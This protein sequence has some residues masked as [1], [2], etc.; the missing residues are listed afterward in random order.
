MLASP[1]GEIWMNAAFMRFIECPPGEIDDPAR[2]ITAERRPFAVLENGRPIDPERLPSAI[3][4]R[5]QTIVAMPLQMR[6]HSGRTIDVLAFA[7]PTH[8]ETGEFL[9]GF[10]TCFDVSEQERQSNERVRFLADAGEALANAGTVDAVVETVQRLVLPRLGT[11]AAVMLLGESGDPASVSF[12]HLNSPDLQTALALRERH[13]LEARDFQLLARAAATGE[14]YYISDLTKTLQSQS[15]AKRYRSFMHDLIGA[16]RIAAAICVPM[17]MRGVSLGAIM[18]ADRRHGRFREEDL[19]LLEDLAR[20]GAGAL[21]NARLLQRHL[22]SSLSLQRALLPARLPHLE[23]VNFDAVYEPGEDEALVGG[24]WYDAFELQDGRVMVTIGDVTGR[25]LHAAVLMSKVR[26]SL[27][28]LSYYESDPAKLLDIA[29][30]TLQ[31]RH[32][33]AIV[34]ALVGV[35]DRRDLTFRYATAGHPMPFLRRG[36]AVILLPGHGLPIGLRDPGESSTV[37]VELAHGDVLLM[38][39]DGLIESTHDLAEGEARVRE[40]LRA[41]SSGEIA[42]HVE[43]VVL[44]RGSPDD[45]ALL[46]L[47]FMD[48]RGN[49]AKRT[50]GFDFDAQ[51]VRMARESRLCITAFLRELGA[52]EEKL[53]AA[54]LVYGELIS[55]VVRHAPGHVYA[56]IDWTGD[57][58]ELRV[59]DRGRGYD[60]RSSLPGDL[61]SESGRGLFIVEAFT[62]SFE[63]SRAPHGGSDVRALLDIPRLM[64]AQR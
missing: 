27:S 9:G 8:H 5:G 64:V 14:S 54:E 36:E 52:P 62:R 35:V 49:A 42:H 21:E 44:P 53:H 45:V 37:T 16:L 6:L 11:F 33:D 25:G 15:Y 48:G 51:D 29:Q 55:N 17:R 61:M 31:R 28:A 34:T 19:R 40:A 57:Y 20:R 63:V 23:D 38:Y 12:Y 41:K 47:E 30:S 50:L 26:Q 59:T 18:V 58:P 24:D 1:D 4:A 60:K 13:G 32:P 43:R 46:A 39:T 2:F 22:E 56:G 3:S 10:V 7:G